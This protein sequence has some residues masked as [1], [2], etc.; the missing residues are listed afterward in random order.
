[1]TTALSTLPDY[2]NPPVTEVVCGILFNPIQSLLTPHFGLLWEKFKPDYPQCQEVSP[3]APTIEKFD[4]PPT[5]GIQWSD[6]PPL[7]RV[8]FLDTSGNAIIQIQRDRFHHNWKKAQPQDRYPRYEVV[9]QSFQERFSCFETFLKEMKLEAVEPCQYEMTYINHI[10]QGQGWN[11]LSEIER[12]FPHLTW[13]A[14]AQR[15]LPSFE[16][17]NWQTSFVLPNRIG[18]LHATISYGVIYQDVQPVPILQ[19]ELTARGIDNHKSLETMRDWFDLAHEWI[20]SG[21][22]DLTSEEIQNNVWK[23][24]NKEAEQE[25][26]S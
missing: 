1:M 14:K 17:I 3:L 20:V 7:P 11:T 23:K 9:V 5:L 10:V 25:K 13:Q 4:E 24:K 6:T 2:E 26:M 18:R 16:T 22:A 12:V 19:L 21:F 15:F 8:W